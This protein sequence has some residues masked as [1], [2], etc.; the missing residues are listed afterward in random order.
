[1][2]SRGTFVIILSLVVLGWTSIAIA[3]TGEFGG[4]VPGRVVHDGWEMQDRLQ[5]ER[6]MTPAKSTTRT[7]RSYGEINSERSKGGFKATNGN[8]TSD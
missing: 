8:K 4:Q 6:S 1:M 5:R 7:G 3:Q 2:R